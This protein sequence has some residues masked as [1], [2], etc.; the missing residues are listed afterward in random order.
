MDSFP[1]LVIRGIC[2]YADS[3]KNK[4]WREY[5]AAAAAAYAKEILS[6]I[7]ASLVAKTPAVSLAKLNAGESLSS[8]F[9]LVLFVP[10]SR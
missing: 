2:N 6:V 9:W 8:G 5:A 1:C 4:R 3:R 10:G 7:P